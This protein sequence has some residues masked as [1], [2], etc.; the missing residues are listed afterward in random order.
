MNDMIKPKPTVLYFH[1]NGN[2]KEN[3]NW[4]LPSL[5]SL[6]YLVISQGA[7]FPR[8]CSLPTN[9]QNTQQQQQQQ[10][11]RKRP[12]DSVYYY[13][14]HLMT[15]KQILLAPCEE[16]NAWPFR[17][18][19]GICPWKKKPRSS[20]NLTVLD[21]MAHRISGRGF[22]PAGELPFYCLSF[23]VDYRVLAGEQPA[24]VSSGLILMLDFWWRTPS[25]SSNWEWGWRGGNFRLFK[26]GSSHLGQLG[27]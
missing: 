19:Y 11:N 14:F 6:I 8:Q 26:H 12:I 3:E 23:S 16:Y 4:L 1:Q 22:S 25:H 9:K 18:I 24:C 5:A 17:Q 2:N 21:P 20:K 15:F 13:F 27:E 7:N 10:P